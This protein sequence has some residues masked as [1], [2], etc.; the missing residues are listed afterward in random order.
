M[1]KKSIAPGGLRSFADGRPLGSALYFLATI[2]S[3]AGQRK[4]R[5]SPRSKILAEASGDGYQYIFYSKP[6]QSCLALTSILK[7]LEGL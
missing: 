7:A 1:D 6:T 2:A 5:I 4:L 3:G